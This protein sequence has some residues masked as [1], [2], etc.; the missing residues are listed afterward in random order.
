MDEDEEED[1]DADADDDDDDDDDDDNDSNINI[2]FGSKW[3]AINRSSASQIWEHYS[4][5]WKRTDVDLKWGGCFQ[6]LRGTTT[7]HRR[8]TGTKE[9]NRHM[10]RDMRL[11]PKLRTLQPG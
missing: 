6:N 9:C 8:H 1:D 2:N 3:E 5:R 11:L 10:K 4:S 7:Q